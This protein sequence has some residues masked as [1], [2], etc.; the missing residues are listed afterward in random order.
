MIEIET[1]VVLVVAA[2]VQHHAVFLLIHVREEPIGLAAVLRDVQRVAREVAGVEEAIH[3]VVERARLERVVL[4]AEGRGV[5]N[6]QLARHN[7]SC[8]IQEFTL[9]V[10]FE[11]VVLRPVHLAAEFVVSVLGAQRKLRG[12]FGEPRA[13]TRPDL[14]DAR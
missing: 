4:E 5:R 10:R 9:F 12:A 14:N 8:R 11:R 7:L 13:A 1:E 3:L 6:A 2:A